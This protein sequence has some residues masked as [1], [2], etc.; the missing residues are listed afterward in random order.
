MKPGALDEMRGCDES[1]L[2]AQM[3]HRVGGGLARVLDLT[4]A[5]RT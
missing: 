3:D 2:V 1:A 5:F 4:D